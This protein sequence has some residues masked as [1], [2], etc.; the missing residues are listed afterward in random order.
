MNTDGFPAGGY[1]AMIARDDDDDYHVAF[2]AAPLECAEV[3]RPGYYDSV[4]FASENG[5]TPGVFSPLSN[6]Y[7]EQNLYT[8]HQLAAAGHTPGTIFN[9]VSI[10]VGG[11]LSD[12]FF[13]GGGGR[14]PC[15]VGFVGVRVLGERNDSECCA[16]M[17]NPSLLASLY[18]PP[19]LLTHTRDTRAGR[20]W[21]RR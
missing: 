18:T 6:Y 15:V 8:A 7:V 14:C 12:L 3:P 13:L 9:T 20:R 21:T 4:A 5:G 16:T 17:T 19:P 11:L 1:Q 10:M 2:C